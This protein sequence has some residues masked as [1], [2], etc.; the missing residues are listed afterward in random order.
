LILNLIKDRR[1]VIVCLLLSTVTLATYWLVLDNDFIHLDD[2]DYVTNNEHVLSGLR[3]QN[4]EWAFR[5]GYASNWH[6][7]TWISHQLDA[8]LFGMKP[9][10]HHLTSLVFHIANSLLLFSL[11]QRMTGAT[12]RSAFVAA[13]FAL[14]PL[15]VESVA[16]V[17]E[18][19]DVLS[20]FFFMLTLL[21]Y[22]K[23]AERRTKRGE[24]LDKSK[25]QS[26]RSKV[27]ESVTSGEWPVGSRVEGRGSRKLRALRYY[28]LALFLFALGLMSKPMLVTLPFVL[29]L[30]DYWP[31][32]RFQLKT[33][34]SKLRTLL[35]LLW[36]KL[37]FLTLSLAS[38]I[39]TFLVQSRGHAVSS[40]VGLEPRLANAICSYLKYLGKAIWPVNL[41]IFYPH[42]NF[43]SSSLNVFGSPGPSP[44]TWQVIAAALMLVA[45]SSWALLRPKREPWFA[46]GWFWYLGTLV[47]VIGVVQVGW[48]AMADRY[49]YIPLI[50]IF[51]LVAWGAAA[52]LG[53]LHWH[54]RVVGAA[55][56]AAALAC[57]AVAHNQLKYWRTNFT[58]FE[59]ALAATGRNAMADW[60]L[61]VE[62]ALQGKHDLAIQHFRRTLEEAPTHERARVALGHTLSLQRKNDEAV[63][64]YQT[65]L[66][67]NPSNSDALNDLAWIRASVPEA[68]LRNG[69]E[70]VKFAEQ[71]CKLTEFRDPQL[72]GT[73]AAAYAEA[74][75]FDEAIKTAEK[76]KALA[77]ALGKRNL[78]DRNQEL[79]EFYQAR[80]PYHE[81]AGERRN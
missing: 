74:G 45:L 79:L 10:G 48:Q 38:S 78:A 12:G 54:Q 73:L 7:L 18:R 15:H 37:P 47:P 57:A 71:A 69:A 6:P 42:P 1:T 49:T 61:G 9:G 76:A 2:P 3:W 31:L 34:N 23:Y 59:H 17:S 25:V 36:E 62:F 39:I 27:T 65:V 44:W 30:L 8:Q 28:A 29:L 19:K 72:I 58:V 20:A 35:P 43:S 67:L 64:E 24:G 51:V 5:T 40:G 55:G 50:G 77:T 68:R 81:P 56:L 53:G 14:H 60:S 66:K 22:A 13:L 21:A 32:G 16:W 4:V 52:L 41:S 26:P 11:L 33:Q 80:K 63:V 70:A 46:V 75:Q